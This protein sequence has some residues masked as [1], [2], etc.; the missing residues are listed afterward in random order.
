MIIINCRFMKRCGRRSAP[1]RKPVINVAN[2]LPILNGLMTVCIA[3]GDF[4]LNSVAKGTSPSVGQ[5]GG[6]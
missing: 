6:S 2:I 1:S 3:G 4:L 5:C